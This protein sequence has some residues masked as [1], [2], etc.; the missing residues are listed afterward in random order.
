MGVRTAFVDYWSLTQ[1]YRRGDVV[2]TYNALLGILETIPGLV[3]AVHPGIG[4]L[5]VEYPWGNER[6]S[7]EYLIRQNPEN[8][9]VLPSMVDTSYQSW[10]IDQSR[11]E[12][13]TENGYSYAKPKVGFVTASMVNRLAA[14]YDDI[15]RELFVAAGQCMHSN[16]NEVQAYIAL[17]KVA[18]KQHSDWAI[19]AALQKIYYPVQKKALYWNA[20]GRIY[21]MTKGELDDGLPD[22]PNCHINMQKTHYA[23]HTKLFVCP[24]CLFCIKPEEI[25]GLPQYVGD[26]GFGTEDETDIMTA[27]LKTA[28]WDKLKNQVISFISKEYPSQKRY[29]HDVARSIVNAHTASMNVHEDYLPTKVLA[30]EVENTLSQYWI[31]DLKGQLKMALR[32]SN[33][34]YPD[35]A[36]ESAMD[37]IADLNDNK[38]ILAIDH[39]EIDRLVG[40]QETLD[41]D[42]AERWGIASKKASLRTLLGTASP[43]PIDVRDIL[44]SSGVQ[45]INDIVRTGSRSD[46]VVTQFSNDFQNYGLGD[47]MFLLGASTADGLFDR[48][49][50]NSLVDILDSVRLKARG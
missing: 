35:E 28:S 25:D 49:A 34:R 19:K 15:Q 43:T 30:S 14:I 37:Y 20:P 41:R 47:A 21:K 42:R 3:T 9:Q 45:Q 27:A 39:R 18:G 50:Y 6:V 26:E 17:S 40:I 36:L 1:N 38:A 23:K 44:G 22:C 48:V 13:G 32:K 7:P 31:D 29:A 12:D 16:L 10:D 11:L 5:D 4:F 46:E 24:S 2:F 33:L 8:K